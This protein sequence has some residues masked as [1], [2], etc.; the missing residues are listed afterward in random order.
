MPLLVRAV[1]GGRLDRSSSHDWSLF[2]FPLVWSR[3]PTHLVPIPF[4]NFCLFNP[5]FS[6]MSLSE[7]VSCY[8]RDLWIGVRQ[9]LVPTFYLI[10]YFGF[11]VCFT[12][13]NYSII[14]SLILLR[15]TSHLHTRHDTMG[16]LVIIKDRGAFQGKKNRNGT[17]H[18]QILGE[19][20]VQ[21]VFHQALG[22]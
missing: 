16:M 22:E 2:H 17:K 19:N 6:L 4:I 3:L 10:M 1:L 20:L 5:L 8:A 9:V 15:L 14:P 13:L 11:G 12:L 7:I 18:R 21:S